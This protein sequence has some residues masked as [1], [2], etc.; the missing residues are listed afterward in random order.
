MAAE[1]EEWAVADEGE[2]EV[3]SAAVL[4]IIFADIGECLQ[5]ID[6]TFL[7]DE[8]SALDEIFARSRRCGIEGG[9][10]DAE[11]PRFDFFGGRAEFDEEVVELVAGG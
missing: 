2:M 1:W 4:C 10:F 11:A 8:S 6:E 9:D 7:F 5:S 3:E